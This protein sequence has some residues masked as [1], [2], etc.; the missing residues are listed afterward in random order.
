MNS[1][2]TAPAHA[3]ASSAHGGQPSATERV[4]FANQL[5]GIAAI[6]VVMTHL[7]GTYFVAPAFVTA[8]TLSRD[9]A[10]VEPA[11]VPLLHPSFSGPLGVALFFL[12]SGFVIPFSAPHLHPGRFLAARALRIVPTYATALG[13]GMLALAASGWYWSVGFPHSAVTVAANALLLH[14]LL[15]M[16]SIDP[17]SWSLLVELKFYVLMA[18]AGRWLMSRN[19]SWSIGAMALA[20]AVAAASPPW[21]FIAS[22][23]AL[24]CNYLIFMLAGIA[25]HLHYRTIISTRM[26]VLRC[27]VIFALFALSW[28]LGPQRA[29]F[30]GITQ[31]YLYALLVFALV[32]SQRARCRTQRVLDLL[33]E[34]SYPLYAL[35]ALSGWVLLKFLMG[36]GWWFG[37]SIS[38]TLATLMALA[39]LLHRLVE[40]PTSQ[41]GKRLT[42]P[43]PAP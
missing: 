23:L 36:Q 18:V 10:L 42:R 35:H 2:T 4:L 37:A 14:H 15:G 16:E 41:V 29:Q 24:D 6:L 20:V 5:R 1:V 32:Y 3:H 39:W 9:L 33:A 21:G 28:S 40:L 8:A 13:L 31:Y 30:P 34:L 27:A 22:M 25:F 26:L 12:I 7:F 17:I 38:V 19:F 11:W 43:V